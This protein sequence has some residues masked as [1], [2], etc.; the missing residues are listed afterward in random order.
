M[1]RF[2]IISVIIINLTLIGIGAYYLFREKSNPNELVL[3]GNVDVRQV[4]IGFRVPGRVAELYFEEGDFVAKDTLM[5]VLEKSPYDSQIRE[6]R[7]NLESVR[8]NLENAQILLGRNQQAVGFGG[9]SDEDVDNSYASAQALLANFYAAEAAVQ[10]AIDNWSTQ[11]CALRPM[12][13]SSLGSESQE[14]LSMLWILYTPCLSAPLSGSALT[15]MNR[16]WD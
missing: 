14:R 11:K 5:A 16:N 13:S 7:A 15:S 12:G 10:I 1:K 8:A 4:D 9:V 3:Y 6:A 2:I